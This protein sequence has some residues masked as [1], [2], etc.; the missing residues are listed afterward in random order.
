MLVQAGNAAL[1]QLLHM[2]RHPAVPASS[3]APLRPPPSLQQVGQW[4]PLPQLSIADLLLDNHPLSFLLV[5][6]E[7]RFFSHSRLASC[8]R[9]VSLRSSSCMAR[10]LASPRGPHGQQGDQSLVR[11]TAKQEPGC[12][13]ATRGSTHPMSSFSRQA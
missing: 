3:A 13:L 4:L 7:R 11:R 5:A 10:L 1:R 2:P 6:E 9:Q 12:M 8:E